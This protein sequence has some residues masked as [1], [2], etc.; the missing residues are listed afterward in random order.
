MESSPALLAS[1]TARNNV[2]AYFSFDNIGTSAPYTILS[3]FG[4]AINARIV[5]SPYSI[6]EGLYYYD[7]VAPPLAPSPIPFVGSG[8]IAVSV[9]AN[10]PVSID[11]VGASTTVLNVTSLPASGALFSRDATGAKTTQIT[12][13]GTVVVN[14]GVI[15]ESAAALGSDISF[16][17]TADGDSAIVHLMRNR[18]PTPRNTTFYM[19]GDSTGTFWLGRRIYRDLTHPLPYSLYTIEPDGDAVNITL[20]N[21]PSVGTLSYGDVELTPSDIPYEFDGAAAVELSYALKSLV[22]SI[23]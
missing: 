2:L 10:E 5:S 19:R 6:L 14:G 13:A 1:P 18:A 7:P 8:S 23:C 4:G 3:D 12:T 11:L 17:Y 15:F 20:L 22:R 9:R 21:L 16:S